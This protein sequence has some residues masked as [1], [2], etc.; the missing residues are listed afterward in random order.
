M[1]VSTCQRGAGISSPQRGQ[2]SFS[3]LG[4][5]DNT[6]NKPLQNGQAEVLVSIGIHFVVLFGRHVFG[7]ALKRCFFL[8]VH[9][10]YRSRHAFICPASEDLPF[11]SPYTDR[12]RE[13]A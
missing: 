2:G 3:A 5:T 1:E 10:L 8:Y 11:A 7:V 12:G 9:S 4:A 6:G 13:N